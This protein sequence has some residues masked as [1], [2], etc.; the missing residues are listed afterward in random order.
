[1]VVGSGTATRRAGGEDRVADAPE[2]VVAAASQL[3]LVAVEHAQGWAKMAIADD[4]AALASE[5]AALGERESQRSAE[6]AA[7]KAAAQKAFEAQATAETRLVDLDRLSQSLACSAMTY[8]SS[9]MPRLPSGTSYHVGSLRHATPMTRLNATLSRSA[10]RS[11]RNFGRARIAG[12]KKLIGPAG[13]Q[14]SADA[15][16]SMEA[17][18]RSP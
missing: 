4:V 1:M 5:R 2:P 7:A 11:M 12:C 3:W 8:K 16:R 15:P 10:R 14:Q 18:T 6:L 13:R 17:L 9:A